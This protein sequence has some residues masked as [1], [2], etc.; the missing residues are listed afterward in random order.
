M[1]TVE[2]CFVICNDERQ[3]F[4]LEMIAWVTD[5]ST[6]EK[7]VNWA[8]NWQNFCAEMAKILFRIKCSKWNTV[9]SSLGPAADRTPFLTG[10]RLLHRLQ[11]ANVNPLFEIANVLL[12]FLLASSIYWLKYT[13]KA[14]QFRKCK[15]KKKMVSSG[16]KRRR[17]PTKRFHCECLMQGF[18]I[19]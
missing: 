10:W 9:K 13:E 18:G 6:E 7:P 3:A 11:Y 8:S 19:P 15:C 16:G 12:C 4:K 17:W 5:R 14:S 1:A 2:W